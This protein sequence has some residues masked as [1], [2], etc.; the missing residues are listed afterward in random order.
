MRNFQVIIDDRTYFVQADNPA[1]A[2][3]EALALYMLVN[4]ELPNVVTTVDVT[5][6]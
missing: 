4:D 6:A 3:G 5:E 2:S 1:D